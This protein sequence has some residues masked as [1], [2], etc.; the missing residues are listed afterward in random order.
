[1]K[2]FKIEKGDLVSVTCN[3]G[4]RSESFFGEVIQTPTDG[5]CGPWV[6][7]GYSEFF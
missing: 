6:I 2:I 7:Y 4:N 5:G 3:N 1:M